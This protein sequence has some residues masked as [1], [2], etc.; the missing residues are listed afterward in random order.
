MNLKSLFG[1]KT[2]SDVSPE[3]QAMAERVSTAAGCEALAEEL[4]QQLSQNAAGDIPRNSVLRRKLAELARLRKAHA[5]AQDRVRVAAVVKR[6]QDTAS[7]ALKAAEAKLKAAGE[8]TA[9]AAAALADRTAE[10][11]RMKQ[12]LTELHAAADKAVEIARKG[13][14]DAVAADDVSAEGEAAAFAAVKKAQAHRETCGELQTARI[15]SREA[16]LS[17][18]QRASADASGAIAQAQDDLSLAR[19]QLALVEY[20]QAAQSMVDAYIKQLSLSS[21]GSDGRAFKGSAIHELDLT[22]A[23]A[24]RAVLGS[25]LIG[26][27]GRVRGYA[28]ADMATALKPVDLALLTTEIPAPKQLERPLDLPNPFMHVEGSVD[29]GQVMGELKRATVGMSEAEFYGLCDR[30][31]AQAGVAIPGRSW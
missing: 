16:G 5:I 24:E 11:D 3:L 14:A 23:S 27:S 21:F 18:L 15:K 4:E 12:D 26:E 20:D 31:R 8:A 7:K 2:A 28:L 9:K 29:H 1:L 6:D 22:F 25:R 19:L 17:D 30:L 10:V 13:F